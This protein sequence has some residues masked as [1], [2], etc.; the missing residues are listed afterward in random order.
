MNLRPLPTPPELFR[1]F[2]R[3]QI[4][5]E[6]LQTAMALH[7]R[8]LIEEMVE[9]R[10]NPVA[11]LL[12]TVRN[13]AAAAV[14]ARRHG[15]ARVREVFA[16]L[17]AVEDFPPAQILWNASHPEVPLHCF[18]RTGRHPLFRVQKLAIKPLLADIA[19]EY[20]VSAESPLYRERLRLRR[21]RLGRLEV[22]ERRGDS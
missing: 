16:A 21:D 8:A 10:R 2:E 6:Q 4:S 20:T 14:L 1:L 5:R 13:R 12:E 3:K 17:G 15:S 19:V 18:I 22:V 9:A 7:A 11:A